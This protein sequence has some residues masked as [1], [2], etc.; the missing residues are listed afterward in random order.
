MQKISLSI[1]PFRLCFICACLSVYNK[2]RK[3]LCL[4]DYRQIDRQT[5]RQIERQKE[6]QKDRKKDRK[7]ERKIERQKERKID[8]QTDRWQ[9][10][11]N[12]QIEN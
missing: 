4:S 7:T 3:I 1:D 10:S 5:D 6:R 2:T 8:R 11:I 9:H 12:R